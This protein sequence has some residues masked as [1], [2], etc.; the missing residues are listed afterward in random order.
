MDMRFISDEFRFVAPVRALSKET[1]RT[2]IAIKIPKEIKDK[3]TKL[4]ND[5]RNGVFREASIKWVKPENIHLT[6]KFIGEIDERKLEDIKTGLKKV[7]REFSPFRLSFSGVGGFP[8]LRKPRVIWVGMKEDKQTVISLA[9]KIEDALERYGI[10][11]EKR[12]KSPHITIGRV[13]RPVVLDSKVVEELEFKA[14]SFKVAE[15]FLIKSQLT[16]E[17]PIYTDIASYHL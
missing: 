10:K 13:K 14:E 1:M 12:E 7:L 15:I 5:L 3:L 11:K 17:G 6:L 9:T 2:F 8:N 4:E 16:P